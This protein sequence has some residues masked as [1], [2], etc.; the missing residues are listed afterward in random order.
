MTCAASRVAL[1]TIFKNTNMKKPIVMSQKHRRAR[2]TRT[3]TL[4][5]AHSVHFFL[6]LP[7][8]HIYFYPGTINSTTQWYYSEKMSLFILSICSHTWGWSSFL[9]V[10]FG[11]TPTW[12]SADL[13]PI[14]FKRACCVEL[15]G[16]RRKVKGHFLISSLKKRPS[17]PP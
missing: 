14:Q 4:F 16:S 12:F 9:A 17:L 3:L 1:T 7:I 10:A 6:Y 2:S 5:R 8:Y 15:T 11:G 13:I